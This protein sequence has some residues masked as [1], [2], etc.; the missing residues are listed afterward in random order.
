MR[1]M[2]LY[3]ILAMTFLLGGSLSSEKPYVSEHVSQEFAPV[4]HVAVASGTS[5]Q[6]NVCCSGLFPLT[7]ISLFRPFFESSMTSWAKQPV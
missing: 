1:R 3:N 6:R 5:V 2:I 7:V 4:L